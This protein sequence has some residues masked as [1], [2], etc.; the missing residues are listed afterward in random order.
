M[1]FLHPYSPVSNFHVK[2]TKISSHPAEL[3]LLNYERS[4][5]LK[6]TFDMFIS[7]FSCQKSA[8]PK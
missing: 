5:L 3:R 8:F 1:L 2:N 7:H 6:I 4:V